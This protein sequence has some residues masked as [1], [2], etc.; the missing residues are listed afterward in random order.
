Y[1]SNEDDGEM[2]VI[3]VASG[4]RTGEVKV[5][6]EPE[7]VKVSPDGKTVYVTSEVASMVHV[8]DAASGKVVK[9]IK[10]G[11]RPRRF[12]ISPD[13][14]EL[15]R[16]SELDASV[17]VVDT[18][19]LEVVDTLRFE[20]KGA[21]SEDITPVGLTF[22]RDGKRAFVGLGKANHVAFVDVASRKVQQLVL[23]GK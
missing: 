15:W 17:S 5:G 7:G 19:K 3:D 16:S 4:K 2:G 23:V 20:L 11:K 18:A 1:V 6:Q 10:V 9:N 8:V 14:G 12:A 22:S 21:R 13:G